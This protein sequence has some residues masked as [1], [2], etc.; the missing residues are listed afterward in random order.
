MSFLEEIEKLKRPLHEVVNGPRPDD[1][2]ERF[3]WKVINF[4]SHYST[5]PEKL[6]EQLIKARNRR[7]R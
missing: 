1:P 3:V 4:A 7:R 2:Q 5:K 6:R